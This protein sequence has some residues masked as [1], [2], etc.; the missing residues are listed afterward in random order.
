MRVQ[1]SWLVFF[2]DWNTDGFGRDFCSLCCCSGFPKKIVGFPNLE[3]V[4][5]L[6]ESVDVQTSQLELERHSFWREKPERPGL[7]ITGKT[8]T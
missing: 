4:A 8:E 2:L 6:V 1:I 7:R 3:E 5:V